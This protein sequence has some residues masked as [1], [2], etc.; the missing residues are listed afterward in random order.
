MS[1]VISY[2]LS[3]QKLIFMF[4][5]N[6]NDC[7]NIIDQSRQKDRLIHIHIVSNER[8]NNNNDDDDDDDYYFYSIMMSMMIMM[9]MIVMMML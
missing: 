8:N 5:K 6:F 3:H 9:M 2:L 7:L 1:T 4:A